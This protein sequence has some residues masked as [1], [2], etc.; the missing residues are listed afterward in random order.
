ML[1]PHSLL[2]NDRPTSN[3]YKQGGT[4]YNH[5]EMVYNRRRYSASADPGI[6]NGEFSRGQ[7][8]PP[9]VNAEDWLR[10]EVFDDLR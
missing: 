6:S 9:M 5:A 10:D 2:Y 4:G 3:Q 8:N 1:A 7:L